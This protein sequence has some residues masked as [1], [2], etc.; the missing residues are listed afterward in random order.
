MIWNLVL[1]GRFTTKSDGTEVLYVT[2]IQ[3]W[4]L[5]VK[6]LQVGVEVDGRSSTNVRVRVRGE[7]GLDNDQNSLNNVY[8]IIALAPVSAVQLPK[9]FRGSVAGMAVP[10]FRLS[11]G[12]AGAVGGSVEEYVEVKVFAGGKAY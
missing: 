4:G 1:E 7:D 2:D 8:D 3:D 11:L 5:Q 9:Q 6:D 12:V 10:Y